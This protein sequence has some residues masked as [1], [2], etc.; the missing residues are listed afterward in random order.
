MKTWLLSI[1]LLGVLVSAPPAVSA[2]KASKLADTYVKAIGK[3]N[4]EHKRKPKGTEEDLATRLPKKATGALKKLLALKSEESLEESL[5][6]CAD[7]ALDLA[8][9]EEF[10][11]IRG[12]LSELF[13]DR[14]SSLDVALSRPGYLLIGQNG[15]TVEY[16]EHFAEILDGIFA[17]YEEVFG[18]EEW[19]KV[20]GKK[21]RFR[22]HLE[23]E[24]TAPPHFAPQY[25]YHSEVDFP[26]IDAEELT[27]PTSDGK[28]LFYGLCHELG[29]VIAMWG[30]RTV[31][32]DRHAWAHYTGVVIVEHLSEERSFKKIGKALKDVRWRS[33]SAERKRLES[34]PLSR[35]DRDG[36]LSTLIA[37]HDEVGPQAIG[38][39]M[40]H[41]DREGKHQR[42]GSVRYY[43]FRG[44]EDGL[45]A[46]LK[47]R[48]AK[49]A[50]S[51]ILD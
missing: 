10:D 19:S 3:L 43:T 6:S 38:A 11:S 28:F 33:L 37:L 22:I 39:A 15:L 48:K 27:S 23:D 2:D 12:R 40:N 36:V 30:S 14:A 7:A 45:L 47:S 26:V 9:V 13:P 5:Q 51:T 25:P 24:I 4:D 46:T 18:F 21:L 50:V 29:H 20:P 44:L 34:T 35:E 17:A 42:I 49:K 41:L 31:E 32:E 1:A 16:L 8:R